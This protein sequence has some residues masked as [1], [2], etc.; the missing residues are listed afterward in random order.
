MSLKKDLTLLSFSMC[1]T[2]F[3]PV[4][5]Y[6]LFFLIGCSFVVFAQAIQEVFIAEE[7]VK[8]TQN[9][10]RLA[11]NLRMETSKSIAITKS[12][13]KELALKLTIVDKDWRS[14]EA[15]LK[16]TKAQAEEQHQKLHYIE[17]ELV[18]A[19]QQVVELKAE[20]SKAKEAAQVAQAAIDAIGKK[21]YD[22]IV[23]ETEAQLT[24]ELV[25]VQTE[26]LNVVG[27]PTNSK[28]RKIEKI[29]YPK[30]LREAPEEAAPILT[31][32]EL[33]SPT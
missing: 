27:A 29:Y 22:L 4:S 24:D 13:N 3:V 21:F 12:K 26:A 32:T 11:D 31:A 2:D 1:P 8:D 28:W 16:T 18:M 9:E 7:W 6:F 33:P 19:K 20:L 30:D 10:A 25:E 23:Q 5:F 17:I 15:G 14:P